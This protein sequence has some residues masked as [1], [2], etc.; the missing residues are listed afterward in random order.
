MS[1]EK[2][3]EEHIKH[4]LDRE[5]Q[6]SFGP[7]LDRYYVVHNAMPELSMEDVKCATTFLSKKVNAP[8]IIEAM[9]GGFSKGGEINKRL[10]EV[11][12]RHGIAFGLG[13]Q[14]AMIEHPSLTPTYYVRDVAPSIPV[15]GNIGAVQLKHYTREQVE[16]LVSK[17]EADALAI[18]LNPLQ[19]AI[20]PE[21]NADFRGVAEVID[22]VVEWLDVPIIVKEVGSGISR[23]VA[24]RLKASGVAWVDV[25]GAGGTSWSRVEY[26]RTKKAVPGFEDWGIPTCDS[27]KMCADVLPTIAS[28][29]VRSGIDGF[30]AMCLGAKMFGGAAPFLL[31]LEQGQVE[32]VLTQWIEQFRLCMFLTGSRTLSDLNHSLL[33]ERC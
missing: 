30:K 6:F 16:I 4:A 33:R 14:R 31:A 13:S 18:H 27:V 8:L 10:A 23:E 22:R 5:N 19:E 12:E 7:G 21:G 25:A 3:K 9:T 32:V 24:N 20:Q 28:G 26:S 29:G 17:V 1:I 11:C 15:I 2:R